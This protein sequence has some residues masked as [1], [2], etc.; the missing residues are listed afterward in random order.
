M[1]IEQLI[2]FELWGL[3]PLAVHVLQKLVIFMQKQ[4]SQRI[5]F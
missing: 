2:E 4:K 3:G 5:I 1:L